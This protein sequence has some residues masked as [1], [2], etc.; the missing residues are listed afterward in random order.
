MEDAVAGAIPY[1]DVVTGFAALSLGSAFDLVRVNSAGTAPQYGGA[2]PKRQGGSATSWITAGT[3]NYSP[4]RSLIQVGVVSGT[5]GSSVNNVSVSVTFPQAFSNTPIIMVTEFKTGGHYTW[6]I[7]IT[8]A[9]TTGFTVQIYFDTTY[10][11]EPVLVQ[12]LAIGPP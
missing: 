6:Q 4:A 7:H 10:T 3:T 8:A 9:S 11:S 5:S 12:W 2:V 1:W